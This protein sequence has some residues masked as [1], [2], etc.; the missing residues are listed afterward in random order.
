MSWLV[1]PMTTYQLAALTY[2]MIANVTVDS[3][4]PHNL[5]RTITARNAIGR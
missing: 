1:I 4:G 2:V 3:L 5:L